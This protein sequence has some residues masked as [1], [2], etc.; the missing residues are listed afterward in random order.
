MRSLLRRAHFFYPWY[1][2]NWRFDSGEVAGS[3]PCCNP[4][5]NDPNSACG[6]KSTMLNGQPAVD[7]SSLDAD[8][9]YEAGLACNGVPATIGHPLPA[10]CLASQ[11]TSTLVSIPA[12]DTGNNNHNPP[13]I[14]ARGLIDMALGDDTLFHRD[15][16]KWGA[17]IT[18]VNVTNKYALYNFLSTFSGTHHVTLRTVTGQISL[19]FLEESGNSKALM[20]FSRRCRFLSR[21]WQD[22]QS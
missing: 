7:L 5:S 12:P 19:H 16:Y 13:R 11:Y 9:E 4:L 22:G 2:V 8:E 20:R 1:S 14:Q 6:S 15:R 21:R 17:Q 3:V 10:A 18:A